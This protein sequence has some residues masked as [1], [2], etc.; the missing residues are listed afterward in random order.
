MKYNVNEMEF[1]SHH[2]PKQSRTSKVTSIVLMTALVIV[3]GGM[4]AYS[5]AMFGTN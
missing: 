2:I 3:A 1:I 4:I 5:I